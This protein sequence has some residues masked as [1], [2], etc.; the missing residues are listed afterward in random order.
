MTTGP[1]RALL[2]R[3]G[4]FV[5][6]FSACFSRQPQCGVATRYMDGLFGDSER[7]SME[8]MH[9]RLGDARDYQALQHFSTHSPWDATRVWTQLRGRAD[10]DRHLGAR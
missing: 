9:G 2:R 7:K 3:L 4:Q 10:P 8:A 1:A 6:P 5:D